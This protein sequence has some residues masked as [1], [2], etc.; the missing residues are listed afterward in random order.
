MD[1]ILCRGP[2]FNKVVEEAERWE[3]FQY[4]LQAA[5]EAQ[6]KFAELRI[7]TNLGAFPVV[8][9]EGLQMTGYDVGD[10]IR[11]IA[12][13]NEDARAKLHTVLKNIGVLQS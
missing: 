12:P 3:H 1:E 10:C 9:K 2:A 11:P 6:F 8:I 7:N 13:L 4:F 5:L